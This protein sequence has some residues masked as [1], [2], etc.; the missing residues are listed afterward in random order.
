MEQQT[1]KQNIEKWFWTFKGKLVD[2]F[3]EYR[4]TFDYLIS[5]A[6][7]SGLLYNMLETSYNDLEVKATKK[8]GFGNLIVTDY[9]KSIEFGFNTWIK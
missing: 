8:G 5:E 6:N 7:D 1:A 3:S 9:I 2:D 4:I